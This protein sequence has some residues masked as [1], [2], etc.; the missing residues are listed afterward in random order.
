MPVDND[1]H[2]HVVAGIHIA[3]G[4]CTLATLDLRGRIRAQRV[5]P[6]ESADP[7]R[8]LARAARE[9]IAFCAEHE[10]DRVPLGLGVAVGGWVDPDSG[11]VVPHG[12]LGWQ[13]ISVRDT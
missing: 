3:H 13:D 7:H 6:H 10:P 11:T 1:V 5:L 12:S 2:T 9:L 4:F 8:G